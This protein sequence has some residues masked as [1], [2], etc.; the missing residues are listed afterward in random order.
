[1]AIDIRSS[2]SVTAFALIEDINGFTRMVKDADGECD[3]NFIT[4]V[5]CGGV[6][7]IEKHNGIVVGFMGD[8]FLAV[9]ERPDDVFACCAAIAKDLDRQCEYISMAQKDAPHCWP[10]CPGGP[11]IKIAVEYGWIDVSV[12]KSKFLGEQKILIGPPINY[13]AR[14]S[15]AGEGNR[16]LLGPKAAG[17]MSAEYGHCI[18][19]TYTIQGKHAAD[20]DDYTYRELDLGDIWRAGPRCDEKGSYWG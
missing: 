15:A 4:D 8:A 13:A 1:M 10:F 19:R 16:C 14:I 11:S 9:L 18:S 7:A 3:A 17:R 2:G 20:E 12:I 5:L 6:E